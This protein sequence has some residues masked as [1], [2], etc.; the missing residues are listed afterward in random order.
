MVP[1]PVLSWFAPDLSLST[2]FLDY[3][4]SRVVFSLECCLGLLPIYICSL[5]SLSRSHRLYCVRFVTLLVC[6]MIHFFVANIIVKIFSR[7]LYPFEYCLGLSLPPPSRFQR[8][9]NLLYQTSKLV[10]CLLKNSLGLPP[11]YLFTYLLYLSSH[12]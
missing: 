7:V 8:S 3:T 5:I 1:V 2:D 11:I 4:S 6:S 10:V 9:T 12:V